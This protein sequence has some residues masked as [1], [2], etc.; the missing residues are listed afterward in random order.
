[1]FWI[2]RMKLHI[3]LW[4]LLIV[5]LTFGCGESSTV[6]EPQADVDAGSVTGTINPE[7]VLSVITGQV[8][9]EGAQSHEG[10]LVTVNPRGVTALTGALGTFR[11]ELRF[12]ADEL[13]ERGD[14]A[15]SVEVELVFT[16]PGYTAQSLNV[17]VEPGASTEL[18]EPLALALIPGEV[19]GRLALPAGLS[20][21]DFADALTVSFDGQSG[22]YAELGITDEGSFIFDQLSPGTK[23]L[24]VTGGP[25]ID[26][27]REVDVAPGA[28]R[29]ETRDG[30]A[31]KTRE[32]VVFGP[33]R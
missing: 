8:L 25:F 7:G 18:S 24:S 13:A 3:F 23:S 27:E 2:E 29:R 17:S 22:R 21:P 1:M 11:L 14:A 31:A 12:D 9:L 5:G 20:L 28:R 4:C 6:P 26:A 16:H 15:D 30:A 10:T 32:H 33:F 19:R